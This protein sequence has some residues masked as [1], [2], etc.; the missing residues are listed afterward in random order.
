M[1]TTVAVPTLP[2][3]R[4]RAVTSYAEEDDELDHLLNMDVDEL[5]DDD[6]DDDNEAIDMNYGSRRVCSPL[7]TQDI[8]II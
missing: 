2:A 7:V 6:D 3:K 1:A 5:S 4:K 8:Y